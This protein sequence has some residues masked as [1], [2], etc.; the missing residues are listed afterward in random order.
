M[1]VD[2]SQVSK[3]FISDTFNQWREKTNELIRLVNE[4]PPVLLSG[5]DRKGGTIDGI[6]TPD[7]LPLFGTDSGDLFIIKTG[8]L[9]IGDFLDTDQP[10]TLSGA[11]EI[12]RDPDG[13]SWA[14]ISIQA[15]FAAIT[16]NGVEII[17]DTVKTNAITAFTSPDT[18]TLFYLSAEHKFYFGDT[19]TGA[20][21]K[22]VVNASGVFVATTNTYTLG[23][24]FTQGNTYFNTATIN[25]DGWSASI[26]P[27]SGAVLG[28]A[29]RLTINGFATASAGLET[30]GLGFNDASWGDGN[31]P[32]RISF[33]KH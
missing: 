22:L 9:G 15:P 19:T 31:Y 10:K 30:H 11:I 5:L 25:R 23:D 28:G 3:V 12:R 1:P 21:E 32:N 33:F 17:N 20:N 16:A 8:G 14:N 24:T 6:I 26:A 18:S 27:V 13:V 29:G 4:L 2:T 7:I